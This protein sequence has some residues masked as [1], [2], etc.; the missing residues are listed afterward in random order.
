MAL[1]RLPSPRIGSI[2][3]G[4]RAY[5]LE[6][7][8]VAQFTTHTSTICVNFD[9]LLKLFVFQFTCLKDRY[10]NNNVYLLEKIKYITKDKKDLKWCSAQSKQLLKQDLNKYLMD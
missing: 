7:G 3:E 6:P 4:L 9:E 8:C 5:D 1:F 10:F 2:T